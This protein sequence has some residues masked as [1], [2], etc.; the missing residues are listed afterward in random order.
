M[1]PV[2]MLLQVV[3]GCA[4]MPC[5]A[6]AAPQMYMCSGSLREASLVQHTACVTCGPAGG[7]ILA[8]LVSLYRCVL[9][10]PCCLGAAISFTPA[11]ASGLPHSPNRLLTHSALEPR[12]SDAATASCFAVCCAAGG[13]IL[14]SLGSFQQ[15]WMSK[16]EYEEHGPGLI[17]R[18]AP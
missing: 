3:S 11:A 8:P 2:G 9:C 13:S 7:S 4:G 1:L 12:V 10:M 15:M 6:C 16:Q 14:A 18:K 5:T 17:H